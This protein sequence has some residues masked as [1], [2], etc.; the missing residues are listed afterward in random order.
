MHKLKLRTLL[1]PGLLSLILLFNACQKNEIIDEVLDNTELNETDLE[2]DEITDDE[3]LLLE[4]PV[5]QEATEDEELAILN[6]GFPTE[7]DDPEASML[8]LDSN[9]VRLN[10][11]DCLDTLN[12][13]SLQ[14]DSLRAAAHNFHRCRVFHITQIR[15]INLRIIQAGNQERRDLI[16]QYLG[17]QLT[18]PQLFH[19][20]R[21]LNNRIKYALRNNPAKQRHLHALRNCFRRF[22]HR[23]KAILTPQQWQL[24]IACLRA[25]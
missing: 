6:D 7:L 13:D 23:I 10:I 12:L 19:Q 24:F 3:A 1:L 8:R 15:L 18:L 5:I 25:H 2:I 11:W 14:I 16:Q 21:Q 20:L 22:I 9:G 4:S 17:G